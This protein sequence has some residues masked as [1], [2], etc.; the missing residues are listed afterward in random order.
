MEWILGWTLRLVLLGLVGGCSADILHDLDEGE[1]N[2]ILD[3]LRQRGIAGR[4]TRRVEGSQVAYTL[5][6]PQDDAPRSWQLLRETGLPRVKQKGLGEVFGKVGLVPTPMQE[7]ALMRHA[8]AGELARTLTAVDGIYQARVH[9]V[10]PERDPLAMPGADPKAPRA[11]VLIKVGKASPLTE[12]EIKKIVAGG[13]DGLKP[14]AISVVISTNPNPM[15]QGTPSE[16]LASVGP[17]VVGRGSRTPL[18]ITLVT[19]VVALVCSCLLTLRVYRRAR[20]H[21]DASRDF[22]GSYGDGFGTGARA[23]MDPELSQRLSL[24]EHSVV[25]VPTK[26]GGR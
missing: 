10:I 25:R 18:A 7:R 13:L 24:I 23:E 1:A 6:V 2:Q 19:L 9:V 26:G 4:K 17:F 15:A 5:S 3:K 20:R 11:S 16:L 22:G 12:T 8:L 14:E 21:R